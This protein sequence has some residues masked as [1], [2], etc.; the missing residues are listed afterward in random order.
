MFEILMSKRTL[1]LF[2]QLSKRRFGFNKL[3]DMVF[4]KNIIKEGLSADY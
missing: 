3:E 4:G 1:S 2:F